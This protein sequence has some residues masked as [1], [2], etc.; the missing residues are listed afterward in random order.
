[1]AASSVA[2][3]P[4]VRQTAR[5]TDQQHQALNHH[6]DRRHQAPQPSAQQP[7]PPAVAQ[8]QTELTPQPP[9][10]ITSKAKRSTT[11]KDTMKHS[12]SI[13]KPSR[14]IPLW[15]AL[16]IASGGSTTIW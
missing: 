13:S 16:S 1:A 6:H 2:A 5:Q 8:L 15:A 9:I 4:H 10:V 11:S 14:S 3:L 7:A 12:I